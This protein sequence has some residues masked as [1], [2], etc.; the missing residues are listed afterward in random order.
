MCVFFFNSI[1]P[2]FVAVLRIYKGL[3]M[4]C[5]HTCFVLHLTTSRNVV[6]TCL[7]EL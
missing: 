6:N 3:E 4:N 5:Q 7:P 2:T 1:Y